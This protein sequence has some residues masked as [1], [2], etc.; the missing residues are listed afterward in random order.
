MLGQMEVHQ[1]LG[2]I[3]MAGDM[4]GH[5]ITVGV[6]STVTSFPWSYDANRIATHPSLCRKTRTP[7]WMLQ[8]SSIGNRV[9]GLLNASVMEVKRKEDHNG[10]R[11]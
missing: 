3:R 11:T 9:R 5:Q 4:Y 7:R 10:T 2:N 1:D 6:Q 8:Q